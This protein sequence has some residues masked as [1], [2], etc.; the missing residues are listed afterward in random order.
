[1]ILGNYANSGNALRDGLWLKWKFSKQGSTPYPL[2][3]GPAR[4]NP[5]MGAPDQKALYF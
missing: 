2:G 1:M 5:K 3:A 4:P